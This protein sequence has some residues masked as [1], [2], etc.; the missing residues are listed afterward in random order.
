[1][2]GSFF[3]GIACLH[4]YN[5]NILAEV[6]G[7]FYRYSPLTLDI[8]FDIIHTM[9]CIIKEKELTSSELCEGNYEDRLMNGYKTLVEGYILI[10]PIHGSGYEFKS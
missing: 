4:K 5:F 3:D 8:C 9:A 2:S 6:K 10:R 1:M 7:K